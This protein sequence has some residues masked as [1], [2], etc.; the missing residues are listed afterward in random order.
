MQRKH[1]GSCETIY[2]YGMLGTDMMQSTRE[3]DT[4]PIS[5]KNGDAINFFYNNLPGRVL[6]NLLVRPAVSKFAGV[7]LDSP[8]T[9]LF[10]PGFIRR[11]NIKL[12]EYHS[13]KYKSLN[14]LFTREIKKELRPFPDNVIDLVAPCDSKLTAY[15][16]SHEGAFRIKN[17]VYT[18]G[19]LL[20]DDMLAREFEGG[21]CLIFRLMPDD[22]H[23]YVYIDDGE[24]ISRKKI[25]GVLH[26][27][28][29]IAGQRYKIF[30]QNAREYEVMQT[31]HFGKVI[32]IEVGALFVGRI[33]NYNTKPEFSRGDEKGL[34]EFGGSTVVM[35]FQNN[36]ITL[37]NAICINTQNNKE[38]VIKMGDKIGEAIVVG[39]EE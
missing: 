7:I 35:L 27:T 13:V 3:Y 15:T 38:T 39:D 11:N 1:E 14:D 25:K 5:Y 30:I 23:R 26:T 4:V 17:S 6:L 37:D 9:R 36:K 19:E 10:I 21:L 33:V 16:I 8:A 18:I 20:Q 32:Q 24:S 28:R 2:F 29:P 34:F 12:E 22:Y 31:E